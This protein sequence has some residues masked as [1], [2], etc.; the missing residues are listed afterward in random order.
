MAST[1]V[2]CDG[3]PEPFEDAPTARMLPFPNRHSAG[4]VL[5]RA[6]SHHTHSD[7]IVL[8]VGSGGL[9]VA[10]G[11][12]RALGLELDICLVQKL[13]PD[14]SSRVVIGV[15]AEGA[16][17]MVCRDALARCSM[18]PDATRALA[19][20]GLDV[21]SAMRRRY[22]LVR[23]LIELT[24]KTTILVDEGAATCGALFAAIEGARRRGAKNVVVAVPVA[25]QQVLA[26]IAPRAS[27][28][29]CLAP[30]PRLRRIGAWYHDYRQVSDGLVMKILAAAWQPS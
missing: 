16:S 9:G 5:G 30:L 6:L 7:A 22:Q 24:G 1:Q 15:V 2:A 23:P 19:R 3:V 8:G 4:L 10:E 14:E 20:Q 12:A 27:E 11:V 29:I 21:I 26:A 25:T 28:V 13:R 18:T 17:T